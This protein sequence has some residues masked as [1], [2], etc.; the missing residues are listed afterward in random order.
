MLVPWLIAPGPTLKAYGVLVLLFS[1][2]CFALH[3]WDQRRAVRRRPRISEQT[4]LIL[5]FIGGW[6]GAWFGQQL[7]GDA[8]RNRRF[9]VLSWLILTVHLGFLAL[10]LLGLVIR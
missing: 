1:P 3:G 4:L 2:I 5:A 6:P 10:A 8:A 9:R 7:F